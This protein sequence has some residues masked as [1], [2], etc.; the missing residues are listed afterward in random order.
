MLRYLLLDLDN[1]LYSDHTGM[2]K[3]TFERI[4]AFMAEWLK[5]PVKEALEL[6]RSRMALYGTTL[7]WL[8]ADYGFAEVERFFST[9]HPEGE[10]DCISPDPGLG[11][12]LDSLELPKAIFTNAPMEH[13]VRV[14][15]KLGVAD[16]FEAVYDIRYNGLR[17]K[18]APEAIRRVLSA[19]GVAPEEALFVDDVPRYVQGFVDL[20]GHGILIDEMD[21]HPDSRLRRIRGLAELPALIAGEKAAASQLSLFA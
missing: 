18:P 7:E 19:C 5:L 9:V 17:G 2:E 16:R 11:R 4:N 6:R 10:E 20:G 12:L 15:D 8:M 1:T 3:A 14:L 21:R 13:A